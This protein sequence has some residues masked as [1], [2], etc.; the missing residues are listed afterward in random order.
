MNTVIQ[1]T[2][3]MSVGLL[4]VMTCGVPAYADDT[5]LLLVN[6]NAAVQTVPNV[7]LII[8]SSGSMGTEEETREVYN[9]AEIYA[10]GL[11]A[12]DPNYLYWTLHK[13]VQPSCDPANTQRILKSAFKCDA[14]SRQLNGI[15]IYR[16]R[17]AQYRVGSSG[18]LS[19]FLGV[20]AQ[21]WQQLEA[22]NEDGIVECQKDSGRHGDGVDGT[23][24]YAQ[25]GGDVE[26]YTNNRKD[27][28]SWGSW[29]TNQSVTVYDG[30]YLNYT[31]NPVL[32]MD[33]R[34]NIVN[35]TA[36]AI[37]NSIEGI[38]VGIMRFNNSDGG[39]V[40]QAMQSLDD[41]RA[42]T[43]DT[44]N[45]IVAGGRTPVSETLYEAARYW[46]GLPAYYGERINEHQTDP[47]ALASDPPEVY[48]QPKSQVCAKNFNVLLTDGE[49]VGDEETPLLVDNLPNWFGTLG[50]AGCTGANMGDCLDDIGE[51][52]YQDDISL[53][54]PGVQTVT[55]H[56]IGFA[57]DL[58][59]LK[60]TA[61]RGGGDYFLADDVQSL[62]LA[63][64]EIVNDIQDRSMSFAA[65]A[66]AVNTF[67][68][69]QNF[70]DLYLSTFAAAEKYGWPGNL[71]KYQISDGVVIDANGVAA[72]NPANGLF[73]DTATSFW[74]GGA[75]GNDVMLGGAVENL[76][77]PDARKLY[78]NNTA[79]NDLTA[80]ANALT[81]SNESSFDP[82]D[83]GLTGAAGEPSVEQLIRWARGEDITDVD[84]NPATTVRKHMGDPL[85]SQ[86]AAVV[87]GGTEANPDIVVYT[88]T[89][90]GYVHA[91]D[92]D[93]G[94][95]LWAFIP[96][97]HLP[98]LPSLFFNPDASY[99]NYGVDGDIVP[100]IADRDNDGVIEPADGDFVML[101]FGMRRGGS[102]YYALDVTNK[103]SPKVKW[104]VD[105]AAFGQTWSRPTVARV[106]MADPGL[107]NDKAVVIIGGGYDT[108]HDTI[109]HPAVPDTQGA[110][111]YMLDLQSGDVL[112][113]AGAD[114]NANLQLLGMTRAIPGS[115]Q[116]IDLTGNG[117]VDRMYAADLGGQILRFDV[118]NGKDPNGFGADALV[119]GGVVAQLGAEGMVAPADA[120]TRRFYT[121]P[122]VSIFNDNLQNR[123]FL[124][125]SIGSGYRAHPL[126]NTNND[127]FY[128]IR[129]FNVFNKLS[130]AEYDAFN[131]VTDAEL[132]EIS[133]TVGTV[134]GQNQRGWKF[135]LPANQKILSSSAT[136]NNEIFFVAFSPNAAGAAAC[137]AGTGQNFL[138]RVS[139]TNGDPITDRDQIVPGEEDQERVTD[140]AQGGI[141]PTPRFLFPT[142]DPN[143]V[144]DD[145]KEPPIGCIGV[146]CFDPG[147]AN[148]PVRTLWTQDGIE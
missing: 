96:K 116:A 10:G 115:V 88:A 84:L 145:C 47:D 55:T 131:A 93:T 46:R 142:P 83:F 101:I 98:K 70:N 3:W 137:A 109:T 92:A 110:G 11:N 113:R 144:G 73:F 130:Q 17:M 65:P 105:S 74:S 117:F 44:I 103:N 100:V 119:T 57:I 5:E 82:A 39:P 108:A 14:A 95:E 34:I 102:A 45:S 32:I 56:T 52:L 36:K 22:G 27:E 85:H 141:A 111:V 31:V 127:R 16:N 33:S 75:D 81:L 126:D 99:K 97:E 124:A 71:K 7:L 76:P 19:V 20:D 148:N 2:K 30:N 50:Y 58:P 21:R 42:A 94:Q 69:T 86:P 67:N 38:N 106:D 72:V 134:I 80:A 23:K 140:L 15:G 24:L 35:N 112:W 1:K 143:C 9:S 129:D 123:R 139:V 37:L 138:Y 40:I 43:L 12:C 61:R 13:N 79:D 107:N 135:T 41:N 6:P 91:V 66:V 114:A 59:I 132:V 60:E 125:I 4:L 147:F 68:R 8:D 89:N 29:P 18:A 51:Y 136:F 120:D 78:T 146:E 62:T 63:L 28:I 128:S 77:N 104:R 48:Q 133:G 121:S 26:P 25:T 49:P 122:D 54:E 90:D 87:Y 53:D 118:F 64:L